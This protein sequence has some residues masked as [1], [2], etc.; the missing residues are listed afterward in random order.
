MSKEDDEY[1][2][3]FEIGHL[4]RG[5]KKLARNIRRWL[6]EQA[7]GGLK[8]DAEKWLSWSSGC[9]LFKNEFSYVTGGG[10]RGFTTH[11]CNAVLF[12][13]FDGGTLYDMLSPDGD[14]HYYGCSLEWPL[15]EYVEELGY[16]LQ[17]IT[18]YCFGIHRRF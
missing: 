2:E 3:D 5:S 11:D 10:S 1:H 8:K 15:I 16:E 12:M 7:C 4:K 17:P 6:D 14:G 9:K 13:V 18:S